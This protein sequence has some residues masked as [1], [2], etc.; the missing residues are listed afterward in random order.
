MDKRTVPKY[1]IKRFIWT[2]T[3][4]IQLFES[5]QKANILQYK[6]KYLIENPTENHNLLYQFQCVLTSTNAHFRKL[7]NEENIRFGIYVKDGEITK[8]QEI[9]EE[10]ILILLKEQID[11]AKKMSQHNSDLTKL[12]STFITIGEH[13]ALHQGQLIVMFR[14]TKV[15]FPDEFKKAWNL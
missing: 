3:N 10:N 2:R 11:E 5:A 12:L 8:K 9:K 13:E 1:L 6:P 15:E 4:T 7:I 14:E